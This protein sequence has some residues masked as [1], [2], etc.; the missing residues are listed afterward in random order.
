[1][2]FVNKLQARNSYG[3][4]NF[5]KTYCSLVEEVKRVRV[6]INLCVVSCSVG[7]LCSNDVSFCK[8]LSPWSM[9]IVHIFELG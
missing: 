4:N 6:T 5:K 9:I 7:F 3:Q 8:H 1:M 2:Q